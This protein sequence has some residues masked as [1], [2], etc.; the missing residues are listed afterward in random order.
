MVQRPERRRAYLVGGGIA[1]L[2]AAAYL[3]RDGGFDGRDVRVF[4]SLGVVGGSMDGSGT[5]EEGYL[6]RGGRM[7]NCSYVCTYDLLSFIPSLSDRS[8]SVR[9]EFIAF[10]AQVKTHAK[11]R[12]VEKGKIRDSSSMGFRMKDR[13]D[14]LSIMSRSERSL[15]ALRID[16][17]FR[18]SFFKSNFWL[19]WATMF[20]FQPWHGAV[21]FK[22]YLHRFL[23]EFP[24]FNTL[25]GVDRS[26][27]NQYES[28]ILTTETWLR[29][30]GV[31]FETNAEVVGLDFK[32][33]E[34]DTTEE[35]LRYLKNGV[36]EAVAVEKTDLV[37]V[38]NGSMTAASRVGTHTTAARLEST[39]SGDWKLWES[40]ARDRPEFGR[41]T[42]FDD[43]VDES[44][45]ESFTVTCR[46]PL[47]FHRIEE[48]TGNKPGTGALVTIIDSNWLTSIVVAHQ[49]HFLNQPADIQVFWGYGLFVDRVGNFVKKPMA[50][51]TGEEILSELCSHLGFT[52]DLPRILASCRCVPCMMPHVTSQFLVRDRGDRPE[53]VPRNSTNLAFIGQFV[54]LPHDVVFTVEYSV[55][56]AMTAVYTLLN[57]EKAPPPVYRGKI[58]PLVI[59]AQLRSLFS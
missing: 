43:H 8:R 39:K 1:S 59:W 40:L 6:I 7:F 12:L 32:P 15:G 52:E 11:A 2:A 35:R 30:Q 46:D 17:C 23:H 55:R 51:C 3:I 31:E 53:V 49:P 26:P 9:D 36:E 28:V 29:N 5:P 22:R 18:P 16:E 57:L 19:M 25:A 44:K 45:W 54:E 14:L 10:N 20:A 41:P 48:F 50:E 38:T 37:F 33:A 42:V 56:A 13:F 24:R 4:E 58:D 47:L 27:Y 34:V 21:E